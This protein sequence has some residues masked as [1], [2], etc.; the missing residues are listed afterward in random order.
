MGILLDLALRATATNGD[1]F[2]P[3][4]RAHILEREHEH[5]DPRA[6]DRRQEVLG[7]LAANP[8]KWFALATDTEADPECV[9]LTLAIRGKATCELRIPR[10]NYDP[11]SLFDLIKRHSEVVDW[12]RRTG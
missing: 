9:L 7:M 2:L 11:F 6:E 3:G 5:S 1:N 12:Q 8:N 10:A 4:G